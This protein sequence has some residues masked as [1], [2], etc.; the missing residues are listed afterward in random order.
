MITLYKLAPSA[1]SVVI[2]RNYMSFKKLFKVSVFPNLLDPI[3]YL[4]AMGIGVGH[5][6]GHVEQMPYFIF[7]TSGLVAATG[8]NAATNEATT[9]AFIQM[10]VEKTYYAI[11]MTPV[12]LQEIII[13]QALWAG[14][15]AS[16]FGT[17]FLLIAGVLGAVQSW[18]VLFVPGI[19]FLDGLLFGLLGLVFTLLV[20][21]RDY[22][23]YYSMLVIQPMYMFSDT[24]FPISNM[25]HWIQGY[26]WLSPLYH[27]VKI[28]RSLLLGRPAGITTNLLWI[29]IAIIIISYFPIM[30][31]HRKLV[32]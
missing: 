5:F 30:L 3:L 20:P 14:I 22:L 12:N 21:N 19:L 26:C 13:G 28:C 1:I 7:V 31:V 29:L 6:V 15:R 8:M 32:Y 23:N 9:N 18:L 10:R 4:L 2:Q 24:F 16:I 25:P 11:S 27:I 17:L